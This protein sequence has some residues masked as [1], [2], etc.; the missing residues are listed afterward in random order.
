LTGKLPR[1][2]FEFRAKYFVVLIS[3]CE[4]NQAQSGRQIT[5]SGEIIE[6]RNKFSVSQISGGAKDYY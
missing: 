6:S 2:F 1:G 5:V 3:A 4:T